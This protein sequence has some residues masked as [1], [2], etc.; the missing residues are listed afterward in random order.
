MFP[1]YIDVMPCVGL[2]G[3]AALGDLVVYLY[4]IDDRI[5]LTWDMFGESE[6]FQCIIL[7]SLCTTG[8]K[9]VCFG[10]NCVCNGT[11]QG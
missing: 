7:P 2:H 11:T 3:K 10:P 5:Q 4:G 9:S 6:M 1:R 8:K